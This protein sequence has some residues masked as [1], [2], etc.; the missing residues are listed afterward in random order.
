MCIE[1]VA[2]RHAV[3]RQS[4]ARLLLGETPQGSCEAFRPLSITC[5]DLLVVKRPV[6]L[7]R[8]TV[9]G[10]DLLLIVTVVPPRPSPSTVAGR[11]DRALA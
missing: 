3:V 9:T 8:T 2:Q 6:R 7:L 5:A 1:N 10:P 4:A 11:L